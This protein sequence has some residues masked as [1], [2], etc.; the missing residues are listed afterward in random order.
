MSQA[1][2]AYNTRVITPPTGSM[3][4]T[5]P[6]KKKIIITAF[7]IGILLPV[8]IIFFRENTNN[9]VRG[10][11]DV[12]YLSMP[13]A[14]EIPLKTEAGKKVVPIRTSQLS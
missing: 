7:I 9:K 12:E 3:K 8:T 6:I 11:K 10:R 5:E 2:T 14:G 1:F 4:P 13:F